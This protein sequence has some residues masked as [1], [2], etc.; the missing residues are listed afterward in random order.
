[1]MP[2]NDSNDISKLSITGDP[3][4]SDLDFY[5]LPFWLIPS[6]EKEEPAQNVPDTTLDLNEMPAWLSETFPSRNFPEEDAAS[7]QSNLSPSPSA[8]SSTSTG[9]FF[10]LE[11]SAKEALFTETELRELSV[12]EINNLLRTRGLSKD[13]IARVKQRRRTL[14]NRGYA[15]HSRMRRIQTKNDLEVERDGLQKE[16]DSLKQ[17]VATALRERDFFKNKYVK[18]LSQVSKLPGKVLKINPLEK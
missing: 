8:C 18:L 17:Q 15:Q 12:K 9:H 16:L 1:M 10:T 5:N 11:M 7:E 6:E 14:K 13:E 3:M 2:M 4:M